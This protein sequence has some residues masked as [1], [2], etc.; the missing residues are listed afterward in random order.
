MAPVVDQI[1]TTHRLLLGHVAAQHRHYSCG[2]HALSS[3]AWRRLVKKAFGRM[4][5]R[6][7]NPPRKETHQFAC[8]GECAWKILHETF[9]FAGEDLNVEHY[10]CLAQI[11]QWITDPGHQQRILTSL[12]QAQYFQHAYNMVKWGKWSLT[13][14]HT[15][16]L[17]TFLEPGGVPEAII[18]HLVEL[19]PLTEADTAFILA[20]SP[21]NTREYLSTAP[22]VT[23]IAHLKR[24]AT[25]TGQSVTDIY[26]NDARCE[27]ITP[28]VATELVKQFAAGEMTTQQ[29]KTLLS[30]R[31]KCGLV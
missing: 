24:I 6:L 10:V 5:R 31:K 20:V 7:R 28:S 3:T 2:R 27:F 11:A 25:R 23:N 4:P 14:A 22:V 12:L 18:S 8:C 17:L 29:Y 16:K 1:C 13:P 26:F 30:L 15:E 19:A 21:F 9:V